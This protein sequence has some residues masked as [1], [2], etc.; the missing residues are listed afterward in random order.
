M[1]ENQLVA[2]IVDIL[3][4]KALLVMILYKVWKK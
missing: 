3:I 2:L 4:I 1:N